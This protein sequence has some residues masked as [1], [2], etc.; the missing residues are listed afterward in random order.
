MTP[1]AKSL[2]SAAVGAAAMFWLDPGGGRR[3]RSLLRERLDSAGKELNHALAAARHDL[4]HRAQGTSARMRSNFAREE[5][6]DRVLAERVRSALGRAV[7]H[8]GGIDVSATRD[9][10]VRLNGAVLA[11]EHMDLLEV[12]SSVRGVQEISDELAVY[13]DS[14]GIPELQGGKPP[15]R[16]RFAFQREKWPLSGRLIAGVSGSALIGWGMW[17]LLAPRGR[18]LWGTS[19]AAVGGLLLARVV[20]N[21]RLRRMV[22]RTRAIDVRKTLYVRASVERVFDALAH[23]ESFP[24]FMRNV[25]S[26]RSYPNGRSHWVV[27]GPGDVLVEWDAETTAFRPNEVLAWRTVGGAAVAHSG[28][29]RLR[30]AESGTRLDIQMTYNPPA[31]ASGQGVAKLFGVDPKH[32]LDTDLLRLKTFLESGSPPHDAAQPATESVPKRPGSVGD[33]SERAART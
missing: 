9:G 11:H 23:Y 27:A 18:R 6:S 21:Q 15:R 4:G 25:R 12:V 3:R 16:A 28:V 29:I 1:I 10:R 24:S 31:G 8:S 30:P 26:V 33:G 19:A 14:Q 20:V 22:D 17:G 7:S 2:A 5:P 32:E 13:D